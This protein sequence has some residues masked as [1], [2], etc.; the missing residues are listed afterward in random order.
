M[1]QQQFMPNEQILPVDQS[2]NNNH[3]SPWII[4]FI[5]LILLLVVGVVFFSPNLKKQVI[6]NDFGTQVLLNDHSLLTETQKIE[7]SK[8]PEGMVYV[9]EGEFLG[10]IP[11]SVP[12]GAGL[13]SFELSAFYIDITEVSVSKFQNF[14]EKNPNWS[15]DLADRT[16]VNGHY[17]KEPFTGEDILK[18]PLNQPI[19]WVSWYAAKAYCES[20]DKRLPTS[21]E[22]EKA[23]RGSDGRVYPWGNVLDGNNVNFCDSNCGLFFRD[24]RW[25]DGYKDIAPVGSYPKGISP[26]GALDMSGNVAEWVS[27]WFDPNARTI[28]VGKHRDPSGAVSGQR[29]IIRGSSF[30]SSERDAGTAIYRFGAS[31]PQDSLPDVGFR[32]VADV[33]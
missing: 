3:N 21:A 16:L 8:T 2:K 29:K 32:C 18:R 9:P 25:N 11:S 6:P 1:N 26:Y 22:W 24:N 15:R 33:K 12:K 13:K 23:A 14:V 28:I 17:L 19:I 4:G 10:G 27:D 30:Q 20:T 7:A 5:I 31:P